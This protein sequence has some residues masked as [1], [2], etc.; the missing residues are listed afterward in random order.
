LIAPVIEPLL[1]R[2]QNSPATV[3][4]DAA[5]IA[6]RFAW[7][8]RQGH[9]RYLWPEIPA[10]H[11]RAAL[12]CIERSVVN[13][14]AQLPGRLELPPGVSARAIGVAA[15]TSGLGPWLGH[16]CATGRLDTGAALG[17][18]LEEHL[19]HN[20]ARTARLQ[21][22]LRRAIGLISADGTEPV[23][24]K[25][26]HTMFAY[27]EEPA[28]RPCTDLDLAV[29]PHAFE[30]AA[31]KLSTAGYT[32]SAR[33]R[34][35]R[36][37]DF[38]PPSAPRVLRSLE[39]VH[40]DNPYTVELH[41]SMDRVFHGVHTVHI[42]AHAL[43]AEGTRW[44]KTQ[45]LQPA[46]LAL[47]LALHAAEELYHL[48]LLRLVELHTVLRDEF[49]SGV[50]WA[51]LA[52]IVE[53]LDAA[54]FVYPA[55]ALVARLS[56]GV[57]PAR[58]LEQWAE[59][60]PARVQRALQVDFVSDLQKLE[61]LSAAERFL[62]VSRPVDAGRRLAFMLFGSP[63]PLAR[64]SLEWAYGLLRRRPGSQSR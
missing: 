36:R 55:F 33:Q 7:A 10:A 42:P 39:L 27:F 24:L 37:W 47:Y 15:Y 5:A 43:T 32:S 40:A 18:L 35:P 38:I 60:T 4:E 20:R 19:D 48:Q 16:A 12:R 25:S 29:E 56:P 49:T 31:A 22:E 17:D 8:R 63:R 64:V 54:R 11:W 53:E 3:E 57:L 26:A 58:L 59:Q 51:D 41:E 30:G 13:L 6:A 52:R 9:P 46:W 28:L 45:V 2:R 21:S 44:P 1:N 62:W 50:M 14:I 23:L 61:T 34:W